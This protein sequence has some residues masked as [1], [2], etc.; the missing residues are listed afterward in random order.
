VYLYVLL[1]ISVY[2]YVSAKCVSVYLVDQE[3]NVT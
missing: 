3:S 2:V 1:C